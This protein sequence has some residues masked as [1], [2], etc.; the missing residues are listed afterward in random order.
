MNKKELI[1]VLNNLD[2]KDDEKID[3]IQVLS[4]PPLIRNLKVRVISDQTIQDCKVE[5][6][7]TMILSYCP[8]NNTK[9][10]SIKIE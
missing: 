5:V 2:L 4:S 8:E 3:I 7:R 10:E 1:S 6:A 9:N